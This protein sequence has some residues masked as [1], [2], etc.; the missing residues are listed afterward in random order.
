MLMLYRGLM[1]TVYK[2]FMLYLWYFIA[3]R[4]IR[5]RLKAYVCLYFKKTLNNMYFTLT[6]AEGGVIKFWSL[7]SLFLHTL[8]RKR[9]K[10]NFVEL[11]LKV[12]RFLKSK[13]LRVKHVFL[14]KKLVRLRRLFRRHFRNRVWFVWLVINKPHNGLRGKKLKRR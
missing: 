8:K 3:R 11:F 6:T 9:S 1:M 2:R 12:K 10:Q 4:I 14:S 5:A 13:K 7:G